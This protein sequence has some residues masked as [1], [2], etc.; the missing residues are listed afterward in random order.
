MKTIHVFFIISLLT[1]GLFACQD[2]A[3]QSTTAEKDDTN[4]VTTTEDE[5]PTDEAATTSA[6]EE[7]ERS[8]ADIQQA[9]QAISAN[10][11]ADKV[12]YDGKN[13]KNLADC[14]GIFHRMIDSV[15]TRFPALGEDDFPPVNV[16]RGSR[17]IVKWYND[18]GNLTI[19]DD[20]LAVRDDI[21]PGTVVFFASKQDPSE[22]LTIEKLQNIVYHIAIVTSLEEDENGALTSY[23]MMHGRTEGKLA[24]RTQSASVDDEKGRPPLGNDYSQLVAIADFLPIDADKLK[25]VVE[26]EPATTETPAVTPTTPTS[27]ASVERFRA[28]ITDAKMSLALESIAINMEKQKLKYD[29]SIGQD[30]SG[31]Y[32]RVKDSL[33]AR[34]PV[35]T[36]D[37][38]FPQYNTDRN[39]RQIAY[40]YHENDNLHF[41]QDAL[42]DQ[43]RLRPG[44]VL[45]FGR[46]DEK[47]S[48]INIDVLSNADVFQHSGDKGE[49]YHIAVVTAV[50]DDNGK[51]RV[52]I[53]HGRNSK[54][55]A[56]RTEVNYDGP[57]GYKKVFAKFPFGNWNQQLIAIANI[58]TPK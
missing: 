10:V 23:R 25:Q 26:L 28:G 19:V 17:Q 40:W 57:G 33:Q 4:V 5:N 27:D 45:F 58:A 16:A 55:P 48:N 44:S 13:P 49:I 3:D 31:I 56:S 11:E 38:Q 30:C 20:A 15:Q 39:T 32:H 29:G 12:M 21:R 47:Y 36:K 7:K 14:S 34:F 9:L 37:F 35:L 1:L 51:K 43:N 50:R 24:S 6:T 8:I 2:Q 41:V 46:T 53:M 42:A 22:K 52:T 18:N 54:H